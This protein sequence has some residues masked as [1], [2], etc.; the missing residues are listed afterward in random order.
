MLSLRV[1]II[2]R[3]FGN[4]FMMFSFKGD[5]VAISMVKN[6]EDFL[7]EYHGRAMARRRKD[8]AVTGL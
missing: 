2:D 8:V 4:L 7:N 5:E 1:Q 6:A 3:Y